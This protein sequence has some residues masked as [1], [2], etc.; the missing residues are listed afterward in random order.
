MIIPEPPP[1]AG[2]VD[3]EEG[4]G[5]AGRAGDWVAADGTAGAACAEGTTVADG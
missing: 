2:E 1:L 3:E 4:G 5:D